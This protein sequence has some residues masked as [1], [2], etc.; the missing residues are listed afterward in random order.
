MFVVDTNVL[1]YAADT[2]CPEHSRCRRLLEGWRRQSGAWYLTWGIAYEFLRVVTHPRVF[3]HPWKIERASAFLAALSESPSLAFLT[4]TDRHPQVLSEVVATVPG[5]AGNILHDTQTATLMRE[6][7]IRRIC[8]RDT[9]FHR[10][11]FVEP[12]DPLTGEP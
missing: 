1:V 2:E 9:D 8:T 12:V 4:P 10:F 3:R 7:G 11:P 5:L 6:H